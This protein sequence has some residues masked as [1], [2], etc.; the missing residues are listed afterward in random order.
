MFFR[1]FSERKKRIDHE[2]CER[3]TQGHDDVMVPGET[4]PG[5]IR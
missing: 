1:V 4:L 3:T 5:Q 2:G